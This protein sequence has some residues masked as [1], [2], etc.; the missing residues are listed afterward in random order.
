MSRSPRFSASDV[1]AFIPEDVLW[2]RAWTLIGAVLLLSVTLVGC[3]DAPVGSESS[4]EREDAQVE[5]SY[6]HMPD[7]SSLLEPGETALDVAKSSAG[8]DRSAYG[9]YLASRPYTDAVRYRSIY[10]HFPDAI[11]EEAGEETQRLTYRLKAARSGTTDSVSVRIA[12]CVIPEGEAAASV[13]IEQIVRRGEEEATHQAVAADSAQAAASNQVTS[14]QCELEVVAVI[15]CGGSYCAVDGFMYPC[16]WGG[17]GGSVPTGGYSPYPE[18]DTGPTDPY[19]SPGGLDPDSGSD[20]DECDRRSLPEPGSDCEPAEAEPTPPEPDGNDSVAMPDSFDIRV[21]KP[22]CS[23]QHSELW[24]SLYCDSSAPTSTRR[25]LTR[26]ALE[27]IRERGATCR[28]IADYGFALLEAGALRYYPNSLGR[29]GGIG[30]TGLILLNE[31]WV[32]QTPVNPVQETLPDGTTIQRNLEF[33][34]VHEIDHGMLTGNIHSRYG[35][36]TPNTQKCSGLN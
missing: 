32:D 20:S 1:S 24:K 30:A 29:V 13:A 26:E 35:Y 10:L 5:L 17:G 22:D 36:S 8:G 3:D 6:S 2:R 4:E 18:P 15:T 14:K 21:D 27:R 7:G 9:C 23:T 33:M 31:Y 25:S 16:R 34:L 12:N 28:K 11:V 19:G